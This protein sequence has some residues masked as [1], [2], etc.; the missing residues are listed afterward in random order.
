MLTTF[1]VR[2]Q[3]DQT[4]VGVF[5]ASSLKALSKLLSP[6]ADPEE[7]EYLAL[8]A[9]E[10][11]FVEA[12]FVHAPA[13]SPDEED[14]VFLTNVPEQYAEDSGGIEEEG[15]ALQGSAALQAALT[16]EIP[17]VLEPTEE[18]NTRLQVAEK[19]GWTPICSRKVAPA[20]ARR[21][22]PPMRVLAGESTRRH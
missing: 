12:Q 2:T 11:L 3:A 17:P 10:G 20:L 5:C 13:I 15:G 22:T 19:A 6:M 16:E 1:L 4:L 14:A 9:N 7:C 8:Q 21:G 18:L